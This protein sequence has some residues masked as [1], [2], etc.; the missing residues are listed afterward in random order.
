MSSIYRI[1]KKDGTGSIRIRI[2]AGVISANLLKNL[3]DISLNYGN[4]E[5]Y[6]TTRQGVELRGLDSTKL[7]I[8]SEKLK[9]YLMCWV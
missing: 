9:K 3:L 2:P 8:I 4:G 5:V 7:E 6:L 1:D